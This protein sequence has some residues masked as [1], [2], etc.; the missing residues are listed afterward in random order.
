[1]AMLQARRLALRRPRFRFEILEDRTLLAAS[2]I[3]P[4]IPDWTERGPG[5]IQ[6][7]QVEGLTNNPVTGAI[8]AIAAHPTNA[9]IVYIGATNGGV[10]KTSNATAASPGWTTTMDQYPTLS[11]SALAISP[12]NANTVYA[13]TGRSSSG[14]QGGGGFG[15]LKTTDGGD[16]WTQLGRDTFDG[17]RIRT[18]IPTVNDATSGQQIVLVAAE[19]TNIGDGN[20]RGGVF[21]SVNGGVDWTRVN[22]SGMLPLGSA[23]HL[24]IDPADTT[25]IYAALAGNYD[26]NSDGIDNEGPAQAWSNK[27]VYRSNDRGMTWTNVSAG[28]VLPADTDTVD[29]DGD[30]L[31]DV[32]DPR[33]G[34]QISTKIELSVSAAAGSPIYA[35]AIQGSALR[36][37]FR[38]TNSGANWTSISNL[39]ALAQGT[40]HVSMLAHRTNADVFY[41]G[42]DVFSGGPPWVGDIYQVTAS[43]NT[44][45]PFVMGG[46]N[47]SAP[48]ADS[49]E[50][51][52]D[53]NGDLLEADDGGLYRLENAGTAGTRHWES[54]NG[55]LRINEQNSIAYD[56]LSGI[57]FT[58]NQDT[59][60]SEQIS[61]GNTT[62]RQVN[63]GIVSGNGTG[64]PVSRYMQG[65]GNFSQ[66]VDNTVAG[67][68]LRYSMSNNFSG[69]YRRSFNSSN[70]QQDLR[71]DAGEP[72]GQDMLDQ[73]VMLAAAATPGTARAG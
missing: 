45:T 14:F 59:G 58:G 35:L 64:S 30:G 15:L 67:T 27:G 31:I 68:S 3:R 28:I 57:L 26:L 53:A 50:M 69:F 37:V 63:R 5:P 46:A 19:D 25:I 70:V 62:W 1:M 60:S 6:N 18:I 23:T 22:G 52:F 44:W 12:L 38:G 73:Q 41:F 61:F 11:I 42:G 49:R 56:S 66:Q 32:H 4:G 36:G 10:W 16:N 65:D 55:N 8:E 43:T 48:H 20:D 33:E 51:V 47:G 13:G 9:N 17:M 24:A 34:L 40:L 71:P 54:V 29:N 2:I 39:P 7:G 72:A 21:R